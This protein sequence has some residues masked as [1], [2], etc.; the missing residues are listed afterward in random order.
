MSKSNES[1]PWVVGETI[2]SVGASVVEVEPN[3]RQP[4]LTYHIHLASGATLDLLPENLVR[5]DRKGALDAF[6]RLQVIDGTDSVRGE[7]IVAAVARN[8]ALDPPNS[9]EGNQA[10][11]QQV[12]L[13]LSSGRMVM[14]AYQCGGGTVLHIESVRGFEKHIGTG[15][16]DRWSGEAVT[17]EELSPAP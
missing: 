9:D 10:G 6:A 15:W 5:G 1:I 14:N 4:T 11:V 7:T 12:A 8:L 13:L 17:L 3:T 2:E 16:R